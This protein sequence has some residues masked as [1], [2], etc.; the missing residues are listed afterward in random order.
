MAPIRKAVSRVMRSLVMK[1]T[2][3][4]GALIFAT[5]LMLISLHSV[6]AQRE[7]RELLVERTVATLEAAASR[8]ANSVAENNGEY[9]DLYVE[10]LVTSLRAREIY[11][12]NNRREVLGL[13]STEDLT[14]ESLRAADMAVMALGAG[15][16][17]VSMRGEALE[18][19]VPVY[20]QIAPPCRRPVICPSGPWMS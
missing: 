13:S 18:V 12:L 8:I 6:T 2:L 17:R 11:V 1:F 4:T 10:E 3:L 15:D 19:G 5:V 20:T 14:V 9:V 7:T 16:R